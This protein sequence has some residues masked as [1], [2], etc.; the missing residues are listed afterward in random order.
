V[1]ESGSGAAV[2][3][4]YLNRLEPTF[5]STKPVQLDMIQALLQ[6]RHT[7]EAPA[8]AAAMLVQR[9]RTLSGP[10]EILLDH[11]DDYRIVP[12]REGDIG[13]V[14][15]D[16]GRPVYTFEKA[17]AGFGRDYRLSFDTICTRGLLLAS[18]PKLS[19]EQL[20]LLG[21]ALAT[22]RSYIAPGAD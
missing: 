18:K 19:E 14:S 15:F 20:Q 6:L 5:R 9:P 10:V 2:T 16:G 8:I 22:S 17:T 3:W 11:R 12:I 21:K 13:A 7:A 1:G 4:E